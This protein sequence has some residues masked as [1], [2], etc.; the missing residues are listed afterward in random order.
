MGTIL[1][2]TSPSSDHEYAIFI[3]YQETSTQ[4]KLYQQQY[5][6]ADLAGTEAIRTKKMCSY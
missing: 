3:L 4:M 6:G 1:F 5:H 2:G